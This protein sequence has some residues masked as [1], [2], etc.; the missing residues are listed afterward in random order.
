[1][2]AADFLAELRSRDI[3]VWAEGDRLRCNAPAE[4]LTPELRDEL[5][6]RKDGILEFLRSA[7]ALA[8]LQRAIVPLQPH[9][10]RIPIFAV[11]GHGG[12]VFCFRAL[13]QHLGEDQ[14]LYGLQ[15]PGLDGHSEPLA[16]VEDLAAYFAAQIRDFRPDGPYII[17]GFCAGGMIA[18]ELGQQLLRAGAAIDFLAMLGAPYT[19]RYRRLAMLRER[20]AQRT[21]WV[22]GHTRTLVSLSPGERRLYITEKLRVR[23]AERAV[24]TSIKPDSVLVLRASVERATLQA[25]R[26]YTPAHFAG[27]VYLFLPSKE[28]AQSRNE[29]LRWRSVAPHAEEFYGPEGCDGDNMLR[30]PFAAVF[31]EA[32]RRC[33]EYKAA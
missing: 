10:Q 33:R 13:A 12:D 5:R 9:G 19:A 25:A 7:A 18:F 28:W 21:E 16:R 22:V 20:F 14:P 2:K 1:M 29:P 23:E 24:A 15:P 30:E 11:P 27:R 6:Q 31:A 32:I 3:Q 26:C 8:H 4:V 17:A